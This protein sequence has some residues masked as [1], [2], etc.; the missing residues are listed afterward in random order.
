MPHNIC[1]AVLRNLSAPFQLE[2][3]TLES[4][5]SEEI[6]VKIVSAGICHTDIKVSKGYAKVPLSVVLGHEGAGIVEE[7]GSHV[8]SVAPGDHVLLTFDSCGK[9]PQCVSHHTAY[10][11]DSQALSFSCQRPSQRSRLV[12]ENEVINGS[13]FGQSSFASYA[14]ANE[15]VQGNSLLINC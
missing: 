9:C 13:F 14:I 11:D 7:V 2:S 8:D 12:G 5:G 1:A 4:S 6:L 3:L 10:C 15:T